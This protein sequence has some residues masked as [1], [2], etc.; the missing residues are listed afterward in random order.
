MNNLKLAVFLS[1]AIFAGSVF[2]DGNI[3][4]PT[5]RTAYEKCNEA[6]NAIDVG[7]RDNNG[8]FGG[9]GEKAKA[10]LQQAKHEIE[11]S[12]EFRNAHMKDHH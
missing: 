8:M 7:Q 4:H 5:L 2:A 11:E 1:S 9:H 6:I 10:L 12:D 3:T